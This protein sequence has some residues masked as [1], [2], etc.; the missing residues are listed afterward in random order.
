[1]IKRIH[2]LFVSA[3]C[4]VLAAVT[5]GCG[6]GASKK[7]MLSAA[8]DSLKGRKALV[9]YYSRSGEN[10]VVGKVD[11]G[12]TAFLAEYIADM[13]GADL[14]EIKSEKPYDTYSY[15]TMLNTIREEREA[16]EEP[17]FMSE[18]GDVSQYDVVFVGGPVWWGT[19]PRLMFSFFKAYDL[20]GKTIV[21][22][23]TNEGSGLGETRTDLHRFY[24]HAKILDGFAMPGH[25][26][27]EPEA[28]SRVEEWL[29]TFS[30][31][32]PPTPI[33]ID[34]TTGATQ[35]Q[36]PLTDDGRKAEQTIYKEVSIRYADGSVKKERMAVQGGVDMGDGLLWNAA[37]LGAETPWQVGNHYAWGETQP[38]ERYTVDNYQYAGKPMPKDIGGTWYD[39]ATCALGGDWRMP[40][41]DEWHTLIQHTQHAFVETEGQ[42]GWL[43]TAKDGT[44]LFMPAGGFIYD[45]TVGTPNEGYYWSSTGSDVVNAYVTYL[46]ENSFGQ[47]NYA[48][49]TGIG[50]RAVK[51]KK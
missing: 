4:A 3:A 46:P 35:R 6:A 28:R 17:G 26:A 29:K 14:V 11:K 18:L 45:A 43:F 7:G 25:E 38:K 49:A 9:V 37:N 34:A 47:S 27:R 23:T 19:Y 8:V 33:A 42:Q 22:F 31:D 41:C 15:E 32:T 12:N 39:A 44:L 2:I 1:M 20:D 48:K 50:I 5:V 13:T 30:Y 51:T 24:P 21:P 36:Q 10:Y 40:T 16:G